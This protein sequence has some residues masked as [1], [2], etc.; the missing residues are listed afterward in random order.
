MLHRNGKPEENVG[1]N[2][3]MNLSRTSVNGLLHVCEVLDMAQGLLFTITMN[4]TRMAMSPVIPPET[5]FQAGSCNRPVVKILARAMLVLSALLCQGA[6]TRAEGAVINAGN[7]SLPAVQTAVLLAA[8]GDTVQVPAGTATWN[9]TLYLSKDIQL[10]GA[11]I[12]QTVITNMVGGGGGVLIQ[13][14]T[15][16]NGAVRL[17][18]FTFT[19]PAD[20]SPGDT[21]TVVL[22]GECSQVRIDHVKWINC[23]NSA[24]L[25]AGANFGV[26]DHCV[27][28]NRLAA[29]PGVGFQIFNG[30]TGTHPG[31]E[32]GPFGGWGD[33]S[34]ST[35]DPIAYGTA[36]Q[37]FYVENCVF[38]LTGEFAGNGQAINDSKDGSRMVFRYNMITNGYLQTHGTD[39]R[40]RGGRSYEY[41]MN[42]VV[43]EGHYVGYGSP[44]YLCSGS[45]AIF[46]NRSE[47]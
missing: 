38:D 11:G 3:L 8:N 36:D 17:S 20:A 2:Q 29:S 19:D 42:T 44:F 26:A 47:E 37:Y 1:K 25:I 16:L 15:T 41:Y 6:F 24:M 12:G 28:Y 33:Y 21:R 7:C 13:W 34:Y 40:E 46:S 39:G 5:A 14:A 22:L 4:M 10:I 32:A 45:G 9:S 31:V 23:H 35:N 30:A 18:G 27:V 43:H